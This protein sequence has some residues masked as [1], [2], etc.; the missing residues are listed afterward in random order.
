[1]LALLF[2]SYDAPKDPVVQQD[3]ASMA[4]G[5]DHALLFDRLNV[6]PGYKVHTLEDNAKLKR[7][8]FLGSNV[9]FQVAI[10]VIPTRRTSRNDILIVI[11]QFVESV[12]VILIQLIQLESPYY[13]GLLS[14]KI[15]KIQ[16]AHLW[17]ERP[18]IREL[19]NAFSNVAKRGTHSGAPYHSQL[20]FK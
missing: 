2:F 4:V 6:I 8:I 13:N 3:V 17:T 16:F 20:S 19:S 7:T 15:T 11:P 12:V 18:F 1:M 14:F 10:H 9:S 5:L